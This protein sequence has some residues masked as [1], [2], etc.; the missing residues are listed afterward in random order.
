MGA[1]GGDATEGEAVGPPCP[2]LREALQL[3]QEQNEVH[4]EF[5]GRLYYSVK[6]IKQVAVSFRN[7]GIY[8]CT[9]QA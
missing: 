9:S 3:L 4:R 1:C 5:C 8:I 2:P 7:V 6:D